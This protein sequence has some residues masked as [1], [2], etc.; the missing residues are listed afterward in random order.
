[1]VSVYVLDVPTLGHGAFIIGATL[2]GARYPI[3]CAEDVCIT[4]VGA[5][6]LFRRH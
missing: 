4:L 5:S 2:G 6:G 1:M 3:L